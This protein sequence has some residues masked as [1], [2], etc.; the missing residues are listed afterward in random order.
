[1]RAFRAEL[2]A[3]AAFL[4]MA[5]P[6]AAEIGAPI[7]LVPPAASSP[8][9]APSAPSTSSTPSPPSANGDIEAVTLPPVDASWVGTLGPAD[10][11]LPR[12]M[13]LTTPRAFVAAGLPLLG[14]TN[15]PTL[16]DLAR[17]LLLSDAVAPSGSDPTAG[18]SLVELRLDRLL[19]LGRVDGAPLLGALPQTGVSEAFD[20]D[21]VELRVAANDV[22]GACRM[23]QD[24]VARYRDAWWDQALVGC[25]ALSGNYD[26]AG[27]GLSAMRDQK[28][29][30]DLVFEALIDTIDGHRQK[31]DKLPDPTPLRLA[32]LAAAKLPLPPDALAAAGPAG[33]VTWATNDA[34]PALDRLAVAERAESLGALPPAALALLYGS[35]DVKPDE[36]SAAL[37]GGKLPDDAHD[38]A[39]LYDVAQAS[40]DPDLRVAALG[41]LLADARRRGAFVATARLVAPLVAALRAGPGLQGFA[42]DAAR[43]LLAA[44]DDDDALPWIE[45]AGTKELQLIAELARPS[46]GEDAAPLLRDAVAA[47]VSR[48]A[49]A[50]PS[51]A[52]LLVAL[53][54]ALDQ[55]VGSL[56]WASLLRPAHEALMPGA[57][58]WLDQIE[59]ASARRVGETVL[60]SLLIAAAG[61]RLSPDPVVLEHVVAGLKVAGLE[62]DARALSVEAALAAGI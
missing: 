46:G 58:L 4:L 23:V 18:P 54:S 35:I 52:D 37:K 3:G 57:A 7:Q 39:I 17:R 6:A 56:D 41:P 25:Q 26:Q 31:V 60:A 36:Q 50:A 53:L 44:G 24:R 27:L 9:S 38:R 14:P 30:R 19:A 28:I 61:D 22:P 32:L 20:R 34:V 8:S 33:L 1:M 13:W 16:Q 55:P 45:L 40:T 11:A 2:A 21:S 43:A 10:S 59:A 48:D 42:G 62:A 51:Q 12:D 15:S 47:L 5:L 49:A 29:G